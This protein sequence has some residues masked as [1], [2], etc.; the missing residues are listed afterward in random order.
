MYNSFLVTSATDYH[1]NSFI[2]LL[3]S[4]TITVPLLTHTV[5]TDAAVRGTW[6][7]EDLACVAVFQLH[8]L[9]IDLKVLNAWGWPLAW[10]HSPIG[11]LCK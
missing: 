5:V 8:Y 7:T 3:F 10:R 4:T 9:V 1:E 2:K 11:C 6:W